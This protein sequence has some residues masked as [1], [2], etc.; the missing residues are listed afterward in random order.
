MSIWEPV[1]TSFIEKDNV[2]DQEAE[3][4]NDDLQ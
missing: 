1:R 2:L 4:W 3:E